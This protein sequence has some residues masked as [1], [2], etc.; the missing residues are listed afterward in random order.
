MAEELKEEL[1]RYGIECGADKVGIADVGEINKPPLQPDFD[2][3]EFLSDARSAVSI[4]LAYP[5]GA[6]E[7]DDK[8]A[9]TFL[10]AFGSTY[11]AMCGEI[12]RIGLQIS[13]FLNKKGCGTCY[14][15]HAIPIDAGAKRG[16]LFHPYI[17]ALTAQLA[18][19]GEMGWGNYFVTPEYG[20]R[21]MLA[22]LIT[23][24]DIEPDEPN[25]VGKVC[26]HPPPD[27]CDKCIYACPNQAITEEEGK[28]P[29]YNFDRN[30]CLWG[31]LGMGRAS[32]GASPPDDWID[33]RPNPLVAKLP[34]YERKYMR[35]V[36]T[37]KEWEKIIGE[38]PK[39]T[40]CISVCPVGK[41]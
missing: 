39:C 10:S 18:G 34:E 29:P 15:G 36:K 41:E 19:L 21:V 16:G 7:L 27:S 8:D 2:T 9:F 33:A 3:N 12:D 17:H 20:P 28:Y 38:F 26:K 32:K 30:R 35:N 24:V 40:I 13:K 11:N 23:D 6:F 37:I 4:C 25:L 31:Y 5:N 1:L 22:T 14:I